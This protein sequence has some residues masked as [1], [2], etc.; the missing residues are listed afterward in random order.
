MAILIIGGV[1]RAIGLA[2]IAQRFGMTYG[3]IAQQV[4]CIVGVVVGGFWVIIES[5]LYDG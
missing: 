3:M 5:A 2:W 4:F 1:L